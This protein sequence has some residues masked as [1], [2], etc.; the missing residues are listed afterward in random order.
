MK[1]FWFARV[2]VEM[3]IKHFQGVYLSSNIFLALKIIMVKVKHF[4]RLWT[5][6]VCLIKSE[7]KTAESTIC[8]YFLVESLG[9][10]RTSRKRM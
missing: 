4:S 7:E 1:E 3:K 10:L 6:P 5:N 2:T 9:L 8:D